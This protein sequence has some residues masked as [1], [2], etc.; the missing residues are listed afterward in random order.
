MQNEK[1]RFPL[2]LQFFSD[3]EESDGGETGGM[4]ENTD[5]QS[6]DDF[7]EKDGNKEEFEKRMKKA[8]ETA[9]SEAQKKWESLTDDKLSEAEKLARMTKEQK[10]QY[11]QQKKEKEI[12]EREAA[13]TKKEL[14]AEAKNTLS[15]KKLPT[16]LAEVLDYSDADACSKSIEV[17]E[18]AFQSAVE[19]AVEERLKGGKPLKKAPGSAS[20]TKEQV[21][22][23]TT[24]EINKNW[25]S[26]NKS[27]KEWK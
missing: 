7:I 16:S 20:F 17:V 9:V 6:F 19:A 4:E 12:S 11:L 3:D 14:M 25:E 2:V 10:E 23:M 5:S 24:E 22:E 1:R 8:V 15:E 21:S 26:I 27:M 13:V 18:K